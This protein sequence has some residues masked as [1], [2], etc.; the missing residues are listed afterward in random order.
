[1]EKPNTSV[2]NIDTNWDSQDIKPDIS[3]GPPLKR[4]A[5]EQ[6]MNS[7]NSSTFY[8]SDDSPFSNSSSVSN[9]NSRR[10]EEPVKTT[11]KYHSRCTD[12]ATPQRGGRGRRSI[13]SD[14][15]PDE[16]RQT[17]LERNKAAAVRYRK[18]KKEE[19][20][21]MITRVNLLEQDK[22]ALSVCVNSSKK[23]NA[24]FQTQNTVLRREVE[25]LTELL[26]LRESRCVCHANQLGNSQ[27]ILSSMPPEALGDHGFS[28]H[29]NRPRN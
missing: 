19:H 12:G 2:L 16:R 1:M 20:D 15:P 11:R 29:M 18:R 21:E 25:R 26:K 13:T 27:S 28:M 17:I 14:M 24:M 10:S 5:T 9:T 8:H 7:Q 23:I 4:M 3:N 6:N 22:N